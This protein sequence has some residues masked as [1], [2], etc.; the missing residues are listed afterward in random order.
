MRASG[1]IACV[2]DFDE[3]LAP[4]STT[5]FLSSRGVDPVPFWKETRQRAEAG[6]DP[7]LAW[8]NLFLDNCGPGK[9]LGRISNADLRSFG[10][11]LADDIYSGFADLLRDV[12]HTVADYRDMKVEFYIV[13]GG[14]R[15]MI[16][17]CE[18]VESEFTSV[19]G[20]EFGETNGPTG[21]DQ[22][23]HHVH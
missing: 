18:F 1:T 23:L 17:G 5:K 19:Y 10:A 8:L 2:F 20:C 12:R 7:T 4:D 21:L 3:T 9:P 22:A 6:W 13:T 16:E 14:L 11:S 15:T